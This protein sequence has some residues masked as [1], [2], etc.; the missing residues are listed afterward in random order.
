MKNLPTF[1]DVERWYK[2]H[3]QWQSHLATE[4]MHEDMKATYF[5]D[6]DKGWDALNDVG[7][8]RRDQL[9]EEAKAT[10]DS[11]DMVTI[12][13]P[14]I[15]KWFTKLF[16]DLAAEHGNGET[17]DKIDVVAN[18]ND[19]VT[20]TFDIDCDDNGVH[21]GNKIELD[22]KSTNKVYIRLR[23]IIEG[24]DLEAALTKELFD[25]MKNE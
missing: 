14:N 13:V 2:I 10:F 17:I 12:V 16:N 4:K 3:Q 9:T 24:G 7:V 11:I 19:K 15:R 21:R 6:Y 1:E 18:N 25:T 8:F 23:E 20:I 5:A 22:H